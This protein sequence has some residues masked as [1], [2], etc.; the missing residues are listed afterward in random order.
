[1]SKE[2]AIS[3][4]A[5]MVTSIYNEWKTETRRLLNPQPWY[6][7]QIPGGPHFIFPPGSGQRFNARPYSKRIDQPDLHF[8][9]M[10]EGFQE[11]F[12][13]NCNIKPG[14]VLWVR[15]THY[16][17]GYWIKNGK[18][19]TG[20]DKWRFKPDIKSPVLYENTK[21]TLFQKSRHKEY[22]EKV[23]WYKRNARFMPRVDARL[24]L[25][26]AKTRIERIRQITED[27]ALAEGIM[28]RT[29]ERLRSKPVQYGLYFREPG[30]AESLYTSDPI[31]S[32]ESLWK[33]IH[34]VESWDKNEWVRVI[35]FKKLNNYH[36]TKQ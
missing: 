24:F 26:V 9:I 25:E 21:P 29:E 12:A 15:E 14:D 2:I 10:Q 4:S 27:D 35:K 18:T 36:G 19:P 28:R 11:R 3:F 7:S 34:G 23:M 22:P 31:D 32:F 5:E 16:K 30:D 8:Y 1:M 17:M 20:L 13:L 33:S 6:G